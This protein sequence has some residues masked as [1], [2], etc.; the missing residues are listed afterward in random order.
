MSKASN[1]KFPTTSALNKRPTWMETHS[2]EVRDLVLRKTSKNDTDS[3]NR[4]ADD[5]PRSRR[6]S[7]P[8]SKG[9]VSV[10]PPN[11]PL[12]AEQAEIVAQL[13]ARIQAFTQA[14]VELATMRANVLST[15][16]EQLLDLSIAI[17]SVIIEREIQREPGLYKE[18]VREA[19]HMLGSTNSVTLKASKDT[20][21]T[22]LQ[23]LGADAVEVDGI[24]VR[25]A[26]DL[27][28]E[29]LGCIVESGESRVDMTIGDRLRAVRQAIE[30]E[31]RASTGAA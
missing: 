18:M 26:L 9:S 16:E 20:Y 8:P 6:S 7:R 29:G 23:V 31:R 1:H 24:E 2:D 17:A 28:I 22:L 13:E 10:I 12:G 30:N 4:S 25:V 27:T 3:V 14:V 11:M 5:R 19:I 21:T 15:I